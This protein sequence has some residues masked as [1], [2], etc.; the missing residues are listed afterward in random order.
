LIFDLELL[1]G[2]E[3]ITAGAAAAELELGGLAEELVDELMLPAGLVLPGAPLPLVEPVQALSPSAM[4]A[5]ELASTP[6]LYKPTT[7]P[8]LEA[9]LARATIVT[10]RGRDPRIRPGEVLTYL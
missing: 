3:L 4:T 9:D 10:H 7:P 5:T 2:V 8:L 1:A 6:N